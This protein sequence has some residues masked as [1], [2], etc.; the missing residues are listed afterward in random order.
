M[1]FPLAH[2]AAVLPLKRFC[3]R[4]LNLPALVVGSISPDFGY[5]FGP[6]NLDGISHQLL[7]IFVFCLPAG[8]IVLW[9][10]YHWRM[11]V[12]GMLSERYQ[13]V[14]RPLCSKPPPSIAVLVVSLLVGAWTHLL[15]DAFTHKDGWF[16]LHSSLL[17]TQ[18]GS[19]LGHKVRVFHGLWYLCSFAGVG[20]VFV[21]F[22]KWIENGQLSTSGTSARLRRGMLVA[23]L[24]LVLAPLHHLASHWPLLSCTGLFSVLAVLGVALK[25][26]GQARTAKESGGG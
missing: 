18:L 20:W 2:P 25:L 21:V 13:A 23:T 4:W 26:G 16:V 3:P 11:G 24:V 12:L 10:F 8:M 17:Q 6:L 5:C 9:V 19:L 7:G 22:D 15:W 1:P 14:L